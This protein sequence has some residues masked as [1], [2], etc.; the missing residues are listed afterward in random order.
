M[1]ISPRNIIY[2]I[3]KIKSIYTTVPKRIWIPAIEILE[4]KHGD[5]T[6]IESINQYNENFYLTYLHLKFFILQGSNGGEFQEGS[7]NFPKH[8]NF[9]ISISHFLF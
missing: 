9:E 2:D 6:Q 5:N 1:K 8:F 3:R 7:W 4:I